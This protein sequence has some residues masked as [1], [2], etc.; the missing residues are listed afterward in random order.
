MNIRKK[1]IDK[2]DTIRVLTWTGVN[3]YYIMVRQYKAHNCAT[4]TKG[5][6]S[7]EYWWDSYVKD[8][9]DRNQANNY[10]NKIRKLNSTLKPVT[11]LTTKDHQMIDDY[12]KEVEEYNNRRVNTTTPYDNEASKA[13][14]KAR[15]EREEQ[16]NRIDNMKF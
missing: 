7:T 4:R 10:F 2:E 12:M 13:W 15:K 1:Y 14:D 6:Y 9:T 16:E 5:E 8:F 11:P 3:H